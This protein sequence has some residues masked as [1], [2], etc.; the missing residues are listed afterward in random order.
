MSKMITLERAKSEIKRLQHFVDLVEKYDADT[1]EKAIIKEYAITNSVIKV[2]ENLGVDR[3]FA[4]SII[5]KL[6]KDEL[7]K[8]VRSMYMEKTKAV[9]IGP[10]YS[11]F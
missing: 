11:K 10:K 1:L 6:G 8:L 7:S 3:E 9:R 2:T 5:K 4:I